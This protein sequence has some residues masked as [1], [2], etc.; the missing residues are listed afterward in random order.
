MDVPAKFPEYL[1]RQYLKWQH[2]QGKRKSLDEFAAYLGISRPLL[3]MWMNGTRR[4]G[5]ENIILLAHT[6]SDDVYDA[7]ELP[8]PNPYLQRINDLFERLSPEHQQRLAE[9]AERYEVKNHAEN[10]QR[11]SLRRKKGKTE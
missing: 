11:P 5:N 10:I 6:F 7:L 2:D 4:P 8:R 9:D 3:S 1:E